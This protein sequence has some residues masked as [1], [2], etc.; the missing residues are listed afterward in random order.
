MG[1]IDYNKRFPIPLTTSAG[2]A[3]PVDTDMTTMHVLEAAGAETLEWYLSW[4]KNLNTELINI[5]VASNAS[6]AITSYDLYFYALGAWKSLSAYTTALTG[7]QALAGLSVSY[8]LSE[9][10][11]P[12]TKIKFAVTVAGACTI[13]VAANGRNF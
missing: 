7:S 10:I 6:V 2:V 3:I 12:G 1:S 5:R 11:V 13:G 8:P 4:D 9:D